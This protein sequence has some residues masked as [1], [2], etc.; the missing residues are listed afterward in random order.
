LTGCIFQPL[1]PR[2]KRHQYLFVWRLDGCQLEVAKETLVTLAIAFIP[3]PVIKLTVNCVAEV[4]SQSENKN[5][6]F[7]GA[8]TAQSVWLLLSR[9]DNQEIDV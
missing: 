4:T 3:L 7:A 9:L 8:E 2:G 6:N 1:Y 5:N